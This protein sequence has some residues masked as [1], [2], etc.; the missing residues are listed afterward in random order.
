MAIVPDGGTSSTKCC[1]GND[2]YAFQ[3]LTSVN[4]PYFYLFEQPFQQQYSIRINFM[5]L[6]VERVVRIGKV[7]VYWHL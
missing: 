5:L 2:K 4:K 3:T 6:I 7:M 1:Q